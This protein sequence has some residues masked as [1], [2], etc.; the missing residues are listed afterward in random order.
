[1]AVYK[2]K[3]LII[4]DA[5]APNDFSTAEYE[6]RYTV[7]EAKGFEEARALNELY[8]KEIAAIII[9]D[10]TSNFDIFA[11]LFEFRKADMFRR[12]PI[13][14]LTQNMNSEFLSRAL[15]F[16]IFD[17]FFICFSI[18]KFFIIVS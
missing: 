4:Y 3:I 2:P 18:E 5:S 9:N 11:L 14:L 12:I 13:I 8:G 1:M 10:N 6:S 7:L 16:D 17:I 15:D